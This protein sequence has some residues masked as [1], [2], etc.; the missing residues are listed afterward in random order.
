MHVRFNGNL[1]KTDLY[2]EIFSDGLNRNEGTKKGTKS[3]SNVRGLVESLNNVAFQHLLTTAKPMDAKTLVS[4][5]KSA[6][7]DFEPGKLSLYS[8]RM[9]ASFALRSC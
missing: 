8:C 4:S 3:E 1:K 5:A 6:L 2:V 9:D 7:I